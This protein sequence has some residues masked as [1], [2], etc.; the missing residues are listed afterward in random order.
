MYE[1]FIGKIIEITPYHIVIEV[2]HIGFLVQVANPYA[3][4][5]HLG[6]D[7]KL[8]IHQAVREDAQSLFGFKNAEEKA[9]FLKLIAVTGIGPK[10][11]LAIL[12]AEDNAGL[13]LAI[14][15]NDVKYLMKFPGVGKKTAAQLVIDLQD[16]LKSYQADVVTTKVTENALLDEALEA[17]IALGYKPKEIERVKKI[18]IKEMFET[19]DAYISKALKLLMK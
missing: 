2:A 16:K 11:A 6:G 1:Y 13:L 5:A 7:V 3:F 14:Q 4:S 18:L 9:L 8:Y 17:L 19:T 12:A 10:S 15:N